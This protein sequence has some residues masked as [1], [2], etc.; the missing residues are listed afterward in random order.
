MDAS[1]VLELHAGA[2]GKRMSLTGEVAA[3]MY[4]AL[5][6][7]VVARTGSVRSRYA[8]SHAAVFPLGRPSSLSQPTWRHSLMP[9]DSSEIAI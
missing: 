6:V 8:C 1:E 4:R 9:F 5:V 7:A 3:R 2:R